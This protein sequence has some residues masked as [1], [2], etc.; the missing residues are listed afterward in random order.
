MEPRE[1]GQ[2]FKSA[3]FEEYIRLVTKKSFRVSRLD[4]I[5]LTLTNDKEFDRSI[6]S[7]RHNEPICGFRDVR[8]S[9]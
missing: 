2:R 5:T 7:L 1:V 3:I 6:A 8:S 9:G 4:F